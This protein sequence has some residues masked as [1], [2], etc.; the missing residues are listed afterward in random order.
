MPPPI[1]ATAVSS[2]VP[3]MWGSRP[4]SLLGCGSVPQNQSKFER[5]ISSGGVMHRRLFILL[6]AA[7]SLAASGAAA[8]DRVLR[9]ALTAADAGSL[10]PHR[11]SAGQD[12]P[13]FGWM[14]NG[15]V[16]FPP[17]SADPARLEPDLAE[18]WEHSPDG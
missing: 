17:G 15:L 5:A 2:C 10:D 11:S 16:R 9:V 18:R 4:T 3:V 7:V 1:T 13:V 6:C 12:T 8:E 14:F